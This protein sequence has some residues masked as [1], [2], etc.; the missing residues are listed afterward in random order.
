LFD[1]TGVPQT[2]AAVCAMLEESSIPAS[3]VAAA[4]GFAVSQPE[5]VDVNELI[6]RPTAQG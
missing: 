5:D 6:V 2:R 1:G 4:I 3:A